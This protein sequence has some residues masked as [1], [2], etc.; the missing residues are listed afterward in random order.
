MFTVGEFSRIGRVS[1]RLLRY[2][3]EIGLLKPVHIDKFTGYRY[4]SAEQ[5]PRLNRILALKD[6]G[7]SLEQIACLLEQ[8]LPP[9][10]LRGMLRLK[11]VEISER[12][13]EE[14]ARLRRV[15]TRLRQIEEEG[16]M[17]NYEVVIKK[18]EPQ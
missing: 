18:V 10:Q 7:L 1:K 14:H 13:E 16:D 4:Y 3:D 8:E 6:L 15:E 2:Y 9:A 12:V 5:L 11:Q 17:P